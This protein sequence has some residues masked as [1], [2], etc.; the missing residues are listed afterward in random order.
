MGLLL[1]NEFTVDAPVEATWA[2]LL[3]VPAVGG[4]LPGA[5]IEPDGEDGSFA[6]RMKVKL[7]PVVSEY[8]GAARLTDVDEQAR[9]MVYEVSGREAR[10]HGSA[11]ATISGRLLDQGASTRVVVDTDLSVTGRPAQFGRGIM[12]DVAGAML[13]QFAAALSQMAGGRSGEPSP[14]GGPPPAGGRPDAG[15]LDLTAGVAA[16]MRR[17]AIV[18]VCGLAIV[19]LGVAVLIRRRRSARAAWGRGPTAFA[20]PPWA[21]YAPPPWP[22]PP[23]WAPE[24]AGEPSAASA[25]RTARTMF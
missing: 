21:G 14:K 18:A 15:T 2:A 3:D 1:H 16:V 12:Q 24:G 7:G 13:D 19:G 20:P 11:S 22:P 4:C 23:G 8:A 6:G 17:R 5:V 25:R 9:T 10:G